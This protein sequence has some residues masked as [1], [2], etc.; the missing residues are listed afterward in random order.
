MPLV[1]VRSNEYANECAVP[2]ILLRV[3]IWPASY[4]DQASHRVMLDMRVR[5][6]S[7]H[8]SR[9]FHLDDVWVSIRTVSDGDEAAQCVVLE[10][11]MRDLSFHNIG[12][13]HVLVSWVP[14]GPIPNA[15]D[16]GGC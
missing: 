12:V 13:P 10:L 4:I 11:R 9:V 15:N 14:L 1:L 6:I 16:T 8:N 5:D 3:P 7:N 2:D